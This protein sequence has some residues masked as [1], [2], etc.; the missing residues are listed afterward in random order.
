MGD[1][2]G[3]HAKLGRAKT[4][5]ADLKTRLEVAL[6]PDRCR[7]ELKFDPKS[8]KHVL[9]VYDVPAIDPEWSLIA[10]DCIMNARSALDHLAW[11]LVADHGGQPGR[12]TNFP[13]RETPFN[14]KGM[15]EPLALRPDVTDSRILGRLEEV[16]PYIGVDGE[17]V[18]GS[19]AHMWVLHRLNNIDKHRLLLVMVCA[20]DIGK[21][22][23]MSP[24]AGSVPDFGIFRVPAEEG[25][26]VAWFD[27]KGLEAP[28][29]FDPHPSLHVVMNEGEF[30]RLTS[31]DVVGALQGITFWVEMVV[32]P[33]FAEFL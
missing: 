33:R 18:D 26:K 1:L 30:P 7:F 2:S 29:D 24:D 14:K 32:I 15:F 3:V 6:D 20:L 17:C 11:Q 23:W 4:H 25:A 16:Q 19:Q 13:I 8:G 10:G 5:A 27:F 9:R 28:K 22:Y 12:E 21:M 31:H